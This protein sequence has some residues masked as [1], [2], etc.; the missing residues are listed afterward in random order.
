MRATLSVFSC[1]P[2]PAL[3]LPTGL[4]P[5]A[6]ADVGNATAL[7]A[8]AA[9]VPGAGMPPLGAAA[10]A[11]VTATPAGTDSQAALLAGAVQA[12]CGQHG[13]LDTVASALQ[14]AYVGG[15]TKGYAAATATP[16][17]PTVFNAHW[18][19]DMQQARPEPEQLSVAGKERKGGTGLPDKP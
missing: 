11:A 10:S 13:V 18:T 14:Q 8:L 17:Q 4:S 9:G 5:G 3:A 1:Y 15:A 19:L 16:L 2:V 7:A 6:G 12:T